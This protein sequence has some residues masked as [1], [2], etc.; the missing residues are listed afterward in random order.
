MSE[1]VDCVEWIKSHRKQKQHLKKIY[2]YIFRIGLGKL[3]CIIEVDWVISNIFATTSRIAVMKM[4]YKPNCYFNVMKNNIGYFFFCSVGKKI[5]YITAYVHKWF[6]SN[7]LYSDGEA[8]SRLTCSFLWTLS[9]SNYQ[10]TPRS[11]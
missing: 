1:G 9:F 8:F 4:V 7:N 11:D 10:N 5:K 2:F 6:L 3:Y